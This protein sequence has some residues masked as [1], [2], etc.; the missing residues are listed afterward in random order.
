MH[1]ENNKIMNI[2]KTK[3]E[4]YRID[5]LSFKIK[6]QRKNYIHI[7]IELQKNLYK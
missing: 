3:T 5:F 4:Y 7:K 6:L 2:I 1:Y